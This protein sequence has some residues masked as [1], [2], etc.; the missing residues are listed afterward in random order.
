MN[1][2]HIYSSLIEKARNRTT[3]P[4]VYFEIHHI[5]PRCLGGEDSPNN[6][7]KLTPEEH[8]VAH[9]LLVKINP[10]NKKVLFAAIALAMNANGNRPNNKLYGWLR[11]NLSKSRKGIK[12]GPRP[13]NWIDPKRGKTYVE[14]R[15]FGYVNPK[16]GRPSGRK[17]QPISNDPD[18]VDVR[19]GKTASEIH[20]TDWVDPRIGIKRPPKP[21]D[22]VDPKRGKTWKVINGKRVW[23]TNE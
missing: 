8:F 9:Q 5:V 12:R 2:E 16:K 7:V 1:Y 20:G 18:Y 3:V 22:W 11:R 4:S 19:R 10:S 21:K 23:I 13:E 14:I 15:G 17:G 6:L